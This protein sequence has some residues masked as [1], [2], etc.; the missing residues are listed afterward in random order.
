MAEIIARFADGRLLVQEDRAVRTDTV[1]GGYCTLRVGNIG[2]IERVLSIN[3]AISG[4]PDEKLA[5]ELRDVVVSGDILRVPLR[6]L[7]LGTP[8]MTGSLTVASGL[9]SGLA[10]GIQGPLSGLPNT[11]SMVGPV[12]SGTA[13][14]GM[15]SAITSGIGNYELVTSGRPVSG[16]LKILANVIGY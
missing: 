8:V 10:S 7:D 14:L 4:Y 6:R 15:L 5:T 3:A 1:S 13:A 2:T 12:G 11:V 16:V 9:L